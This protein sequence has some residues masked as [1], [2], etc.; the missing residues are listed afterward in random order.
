[1]LHLKL[2]SSTDNS[3]ALSKQFKAKAKSDGDDIISAVI[4]QAAKA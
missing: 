2:T 4:E 3:S 1:M